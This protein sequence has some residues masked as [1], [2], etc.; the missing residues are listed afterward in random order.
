MCKTKIMSTSTSFWN[1]FLYKKMY[2]NT[3]NPFKSQS[4]GNT[5]K[6]QKNK[7]ICII[8]IIIGIKYIPKSYVLKRHISCVYILEDK[9]HTQL[10][11]WTTNGQLDDRN[12]YLFF[13]R[14]IN[15]YVVYII[16]ILIDNRSPQVVSIGSIFMVSTHPTRWVQTK[17]ETFYLP[18]PVY[19][20]TP[21]LHASLCFGAYQGSSEIPTLS[22]N[23]DVALWELPY[24]NL[25]Y[26]TAYFQLADILNCTPIFLQRSPQSYWR[27]AWSSTMRASP[28]TATDISELLGVESEE[29]LN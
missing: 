2:K 16:K 27:E 26:E 18:S 13:T 6:F 12:N 8:S 9:L 22:L 10:W 15:T 14:V 17:M 21:N 24:H 3:N 25:P 11:V 20:D 1:Y 7:E 23:K 5:F 19:A 28:L 29:E 4:I